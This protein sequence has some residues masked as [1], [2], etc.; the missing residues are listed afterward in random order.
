MAHLIQPDGTVTGHTPKS[1]RDWSLIEI[2]FLI[3]GYIERV[4]TT[5]KHEAYCD[6][7]GVQRKLPVNAFAS[8]LLRVELV[9]P[10]LLLDKTE[11][12]P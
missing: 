7:E 3:G 12:L 2:Q 10:V 4:P 11:R 9:G 6:E 8:L 1:G 5:K